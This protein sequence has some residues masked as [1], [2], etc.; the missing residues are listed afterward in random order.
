MDKH[1]QIDKLIQNVTSVNHIYFISSSHKFHLLARSRNLATHVKYS[2]NIYSF[3]AQTHH[4]S[5][6]KDRWRK[7]SQ[8]NEKTPN[9]LQFLQQKW[10]IMK[11]PI[12]LTKNAS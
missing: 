11:S 8:V 12:V 10:C 3:I 2:K 9:D 4:E 5:Q 6:V 7:L 1:T